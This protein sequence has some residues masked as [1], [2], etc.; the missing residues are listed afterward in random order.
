MRAEREATMDLG[1]DSTAPASL[2]L[3]ASDPCHA[4]EGNP[5][6]ERAFFAVHGNRQVRY[7][8]A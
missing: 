5:L 4:R 2:V 7:G 3:N 6:M 8:R 1:E